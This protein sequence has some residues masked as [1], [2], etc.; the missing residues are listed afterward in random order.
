MG[1][2]LNIHRSWEELTSNW[3]STWGGSGG[4]KI[5]SGTSRGKFM[6]HNHNYTGSTSTISVFGKILLVN[7][8]YA[9]SSVENILKKELKL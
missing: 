6:C 1:Q 3:G 2:N 5:M 9:H 4:L 8:P 7:F